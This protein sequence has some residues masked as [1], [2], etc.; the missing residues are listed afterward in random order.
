MCCGA[1][2]I[3]WAVMHDKEDEWMPMWRG[4]MRWERHMECAY[5]SGVQ[6]VLGDRKWVSC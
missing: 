3:E 4:D 2:D 5:V 1:G 6:W